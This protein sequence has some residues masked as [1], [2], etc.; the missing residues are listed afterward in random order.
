M[1]KK[2]ENKRSMTPLWVIASFVSLTELIA[3]FA[4][5]KTTGGVQTS[6]TTFVCVFPFLIAIAFFVVLWARPYVFYPP[7][8]FGTAQDVERYVNA[9]QGKPKT[10]EPIPSPEQRPQ[11]GDATQPPP[12]GTVRVPITP[13]EQKSPPAPAAAEK[14]ATKTPEDLRVEIW[15]IP[16]LEARS[17]RCRSGMKMKKRSTKNYFRRHTKSK[18]SS[19][20]SREP[21]SYLAIR[22]SAFLV[23]GDPMTDRSSPFSKTGQRSLLSGSKARTNTFSRGSSQTVVPR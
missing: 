5:T 13:N 1:A 21:F 10:P 2:A 17:Q 19:S 11:A 18:G 16:T 12:E 4:A 6:L 23:N 7:T 14:Q 15:F 22:P 9:M 20:V 8:D 3:G